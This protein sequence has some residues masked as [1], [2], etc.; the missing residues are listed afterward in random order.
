MKSVEEITISLDESR[1]ARSRH[2]ISSCLA[3]VNGDDD[4]VV[5]ELSRFSY[6]H[7]RVVFAE[8]ILK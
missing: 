4:S 1:K 5:L 2:A 8:E 3:L 6:Y 7:G